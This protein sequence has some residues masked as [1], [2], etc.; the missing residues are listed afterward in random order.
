M[1]EGFDNSGHHMWRV[2][3]ANASLPDSY[4]HDIQLDQNTREVLGLL[5]RRQR[6]G[7][8]GRAGQQHD[9]ERAH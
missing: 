7:G 5:T 1:E 2:E 6:Q 3:V 9:D 4:Y 8:L